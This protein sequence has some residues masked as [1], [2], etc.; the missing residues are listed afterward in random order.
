MQGCI[1]VIPDWCWIGFT[2]AFGCC[3]GSFLNVVIYR[4]P[5]E[6]SLV[7]PPS[8]CPACGKHIRFYDNIPLI[9]Y[10]IL[11][12]RCRYCK[13]PISPRYFVI[14]M[15]TGLTFVFTY[16]LFFRSYLRTGIPAFL[17]GGWLIYLVTIVL[18]S[19]LIAASAIDLELWII[20]IWVCWVITAVGIVASALAPLLIDYKLIRGYHL[21]PYASAGTAAL[22]LG[23]AV[24]LGISLLLLVTGLLKR[25]Y[26]FPEETEDQGPKTEDPAS[27]ND[28]SAAASGR[29]KA[30]DNS[31]NERRDTSDE[32]R[33]N[34]RLEAMRE[35]LFL[36]PIIACAIVVFWLTKRVAPIRG[37]WLNFLQ[38]PVVA[39]LFGSIFAYFIGC[40]IVWTT[41][42]LGTLG[43]G[44]EAMGLG[45]VH[46]MGAAAA[47]IG[48]VPIVV[49]FFVAPFFGLAWALVQMFFKKTRQIPYGPFLSLGVF[50]AIIAHNRIY[51]YL[52][53]VLGRQ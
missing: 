51:G 20:P 30:A 22:A 18:L 36:T 24:G 48:A 37:F 9:S 12:R 5:R 42:I 17:S 14:E 39:G 49:A 10:L 31:E 6:K 21:L 19:A 2:F 32:R 1:M 44:R 53:W 33:I 27:L 45:D 35:L 15:L 34:H 38:R 13:A 47:C 16:Y 11:G 52:A 25:S 3:V 43:F 8:A 4:L 28:S 50:V 40:A 26:D 46:L 7:K 29:Q 41:R 23:A